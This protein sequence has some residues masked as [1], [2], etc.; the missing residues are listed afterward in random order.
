MSINSWNLCHL[1]SRLLK[2]VVIALDDRPHLE[3][4]IHNRKFIYNTWQNIKL[5]E[6]QNVQYRL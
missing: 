6:H 3:I 2:D 1:F 5:S 4:V